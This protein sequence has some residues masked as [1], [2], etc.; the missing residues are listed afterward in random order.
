MA[1]EPG[2]ALLK[3]TESS[4]YCL[5]SVSG[6]VLMV[7][8]FAPET[9]V[10]VV[11]ST[12]LTSPPN[13]RC[14]SRCSAAC[15]ALMSDDF[16][17]IRRAAVK[18]VAS[19]AVPLART[20]S[21]I[22]TSL[23][24]AGV[25]ALRSFAPGG[26]CTTFAPAAALTVTVAPAAVVMVIALPFTAVTVPAC[27]VIAAAA[28][29]GRTGVDVS[30]ATSANL[31]PVR[32]FSMDLTLSLSFARPKNDAVAIVWSSLSLRRTEGKSFEKHPRKKSLRCPIVLRT[33][34]EL[35]TGDPPVPLSST[36]ERLAQIWIW[37]DDQAASRCCGF[38]RSISVD[39][40]R[41]LCLYS[42]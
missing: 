3:S 8:V 42:S 36:E 38:N 25:A 11:P 33:K 13:P 24:E 7:S 28:C 32:I 31:N 9:T 5:K 39:A 22:A 14:H 34:A 26:T 40:A 30:R 23:R 21:P 12:D 17:T 29:P 19:G 27:R 41:S 1:S 10:I 2:L 6:P 15:M 16:M 20:L 4:A 18:L 35:T 37:G